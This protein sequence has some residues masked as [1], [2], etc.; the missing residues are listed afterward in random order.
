MGV[1]QEGLAATVMAAATTPDRDSDNYGVSQ[2]PETNE[3]FPELDADV[4][5]DWPAAG[6]EQAGF[7]MGESDDSAGF[8]FDGPVVGPDRDFRT[9]MDRVVRAPS[10]VPTLTL[11][12]SGAD[13][14]GFSGGSEGFLV[15]EELGAD[16]QEKTP[17]ETDFD[18]K[19]NRIVGRFNPTDG[20]LDG[21]MVR[22]RRPTAAAA[23]V[24]ASLSPALSHDTPHDSLEQEFADLAA[25]FGMKP[26]PASPSLGDAGV[27]VGRDGAPLAATLAGAAGAEAAIVGGAEVLPGADEVEDATLEL[28][29]WKLKAMGLTYNFHG[30]DALIGWATNK[31]GQSLAM[32]NDGVVWRDFAT[33]FEAYRSGVPAGKAFEG[34]ADASAVPAAAASSAAKAAVGRA[35]GTMKA[36]AAPNEPAKGGAP[37]SPLPPGLDDKAL[38]GGEAVPATPTGRMPSIGAAARAAS[39]A[40]THGSSTGGGKALGPATSPSRRAQPAATATAASGPAAKVAVAVVGAAVV[41]LAVLHVLQIVRIPGLP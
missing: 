4:L 31:V 35:T 18:S 5:T 40:P 33:F 34:A 22:E 28:R 26:P 11:D 9:L 25:A 1:A 32:S 17:L 39:T 29:D 7:V 37:R 36:A 6:S 20:D 38:A 23:D 13:S 14:S 12:S 10:S 24:A 3:G 15:G 8:S 21:P 19:G 30:L 2:I 27:V 41:V 16:T